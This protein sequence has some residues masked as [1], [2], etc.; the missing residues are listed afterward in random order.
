MYNNLFAQTLSETAVLQNSSAYQISCTFIDN[1]VGLNW[2][3]NQIENETYIVIIQGVAIC[4]YTHTHCPSG[5]P[6]ELKIPADMILRSSSN[7]TY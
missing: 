3:K 6:S 1:L 2:P 5:F 7:L 4:T